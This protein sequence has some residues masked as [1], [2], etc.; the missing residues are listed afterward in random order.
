MLFHLWITSFLQGVIVAGLIGPGDRA[1]FDAVLGH[2]P[3]PRLALGTFVASALRK[4]EPPRKIRRV[5]D[6][7]APL[8]ETAM[9]SGFV[10]AG[11][12]PGLERLGRAERAAPA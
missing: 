4:L 12:R 10:A 7:L 5:A 8:C 6:R 1:A 9:G 11:E 2:G 3:W